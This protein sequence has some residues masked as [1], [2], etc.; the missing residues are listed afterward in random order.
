MCARI[1]QVVL[2]VLPRDRKQSVQRPQLSQAG[3]EEEEV[4]VVVVGVGV[5][6][7]CEQRARQVTHAE[8]PRACTR[9]I[10]DRALR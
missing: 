3:Q 2:N 8:L 7:S 1:C 9:R 10:M 6:P 5:I 4:V